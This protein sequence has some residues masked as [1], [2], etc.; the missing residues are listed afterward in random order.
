MGFATTA[1]SVASLLLLAIPGF[2]LIKTKLVKSE[3]ISI[4]V[5]V[6]LYVCQPFITMNAFLSKEFETNLLTNMGIVILVAILTQILFLFMSKIIFR[7]DKNKL[8]GNA[9]SFASALGNVGFM[10]IPVI[11][12]LL[13]NNAEALLYVAI[14]M[15]VFNIISWTLGVYVL[16]EEKKYISIKKAIINP[17][18]IAM[19]IALPFFFTNFHLPEFIMQPIGFFAD[20]NTPIAMLILGM[21]FANIKFKELISGWGV[22]LSSF[23]KLAITP[24]AVYLIMMPFKISLTLRT[25]IVIISAMPSANMVLMMAERFDGDSVAATK[26]VLHSTILSI[27]TIPLIMMLPLG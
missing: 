10:G 27:I 26:A 5:V 9:Y 24:I 18:I 1:L 17:P 21:R 12:V 6:L 20:M 11:S 13:P 14:Y 23:I 7:C 15:T 8:R 2:V 25:V 4:L 16:T 3:A 19:I 22:Y